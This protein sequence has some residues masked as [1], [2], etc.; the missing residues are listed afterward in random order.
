M[1]FSYVCI[2]ISKRCKEQ[3]ESNERIKTLLSKVLNRNFA[4]YLLAKSNIIHIE[5]NYK[6][7]N[8]FIY[9]FAIYFDNYSMIARY[10]CLEVNY[11][12]LIRFNIEFALS[13]PFVHKFLNLVNHYALI[14]WPVTYLL[15]LQICNFQETISQSIKLFHSQ[16]QIINSIYIYI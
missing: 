11:S 1:T 7:M 3:T 15:Q 10:L 5:Q 6:S 12:G 9:N 16:N 2:S 14:A 8:S 4:I 13:I